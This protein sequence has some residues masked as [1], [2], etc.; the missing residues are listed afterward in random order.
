MYKRNMKKLL[1]LLLLVPTLANAQIF[2]IGDKG[3]EV[4]KLQK[5]LGVKPATGYYGVITKKAHDKYLASQSTRTAT[6]T[7]EKPVLSQIQATSTP[8]LN[9]ITDWRFNMTVADNN[10]YS[11]TVILNFTPITKGYTLA[12]V[13]RCE[14][15]SDLE[16][17]DEGGKH[18]ISH[19]G[20]Y[21]IRFNAIVYKKYH[22]T[23]QCVAFTYNNGVYKEYLSPILEV[24]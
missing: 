18:I 11:K 8:D 7:P 9:E 6:T 19:D 15:N 23:I 5:M 1:I 24:K 21:S 13:T 10:Y 17:T 4:V 20:S 16:T 14:Y 22:T 3:A 2:K 12:K